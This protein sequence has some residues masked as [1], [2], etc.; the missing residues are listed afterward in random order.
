[1]SQFEKRREF[2]TLEANREAAQSAILDLVAGKE[3]LSVL[4]AGGG[5]MTHFAFLPNAVFTAI[6]ISPEQLERN[7]YAKTKLLADLETFTDYPEPFDVI[8]ANDVLEHLPNPDK[9]LDILMGKLKPGGLMILAGPDPLSFKGLFTKFTPHAFH[10]WFYRNLAKYPDAGKPGH[11][12][13]RAFLRLAVTPGA[14]TERA[15]RNGLELAYFGASRP[16]W[17]L[18]RVGRTLPPALWI[19]EALMGLARIVT[20]GGWR[21]DLSDIFIVLRRPG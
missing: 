5:D 7:G 13:F 10:V 15:R 18:E 16:S 9:A 1:M 14:L 8:A 11:V 17:M 3:R 19:Y 21:P 4:E 20:F 12:P 6:D 2:A